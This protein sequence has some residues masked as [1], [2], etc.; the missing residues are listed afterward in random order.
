MPL[1]L[2]PRTPFKPPPGLLALSL[3]LSILSLPK[4][5]GRGK[6]HAPSPPRF[7]S[8]RQRGE[9]AGRRMRGKRQHC[10]GRPSIPP[11]PFDRLRMRA[12]VATSPQA[13]Y[14]V[15]ATPGLLALSLILSIL[16]LPKGE[17]P[18]ER[19]RTIISAQNKKGDPKAALSTS[20]RSRLSRAQAAASSPAPPHRH[21]RTAASSP[22]DRPYS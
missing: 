4:G 18:R 15:Q 22:K 7:P 14:P 17:G 21:G 2:E 1:H 16:S 6:G 12:F 8:P 20:S 13:T 9:G 5:E 19:T 3:I 10:K 11:S